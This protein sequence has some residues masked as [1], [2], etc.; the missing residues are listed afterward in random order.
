MDSDFVPNHL[1]C[2]YYGAV[3]CSTYQM[4][5]TVTACEGLGLISLTCEL[6]EF[7]I[8]MGFSFAKPLPPRLLLQYRVDILRC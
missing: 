5:S 1:L 7:E 4:D 8:T 6:F 2:T 3:G